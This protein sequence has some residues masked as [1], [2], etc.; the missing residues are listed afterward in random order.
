MSIFP[1]LCLIGL[2]DSDRVV[3]GDKAVGAY[4]KLMPEYCFVL[5]STLDNSILAFA[6]TAPDAVQF[7]TRHNVAWLPEMREKYPRKVNDLSDE[8]MSMLSPIEE[9]MLSFHT[10]EET[11]GLPP[12]LTSPPDHLSS[13]SGS[14]SGGVPLP[15]GL[16][17]LYI[18]PTVS[19]D[20]SIS[21][22]LAMCCMACLRAS[23]TIR[24][25]SEIRTR[26]NRSKDLYAMMGF[27]SVSPL[28]SNNDSPSSPPP[29]ETNSNASGSNG[30]PTGVQQS[31]YIYMT[32]NF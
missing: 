3:V 13:G 14:S 15:W 31:K 23:G 27:S 6:A 7:H 19:N 25:Y 1:F 21:K 29:T 5:E 24:A 11:V 26:D 30:T 10:D 4:L 32:R 2:C 16:I 9:M 8:A 22:R 12:C 18:T 28:Q 20:H 17:N